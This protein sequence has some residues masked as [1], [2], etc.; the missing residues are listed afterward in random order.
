M[1]SH[2][3]D[4]SV[5]SL[6]QDRT[7]VSTPE[8]LTSQNSTVLAP[9]VGRTPQ[10]QTAPLTPP[11]AP[12]TAASAPP[13]TIIGQDNSLSPSDE[14]EIAVASHPSDES[15]RVRVST[16]TLTYKRSDRYGHF[17]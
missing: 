1:A 12:L 10:Q 8:A 5:P 17:S 4:E 9:V 11:A 6:D 3:S 16:L 15:V 13:T 7:P 2:P 14:S